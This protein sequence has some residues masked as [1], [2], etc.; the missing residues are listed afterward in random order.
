MLMVD[1]YP[2]GWLLFQVLV[3]EVNELLWQRRSCHL[4]HFDFCKSESDVLIATTTI[5]TVIG[6]LIIITPHLPAF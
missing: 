2:V 5:T 4:E 1:G 3:A 6:G